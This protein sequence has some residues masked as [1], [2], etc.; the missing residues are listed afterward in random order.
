MINH[1]S[2]QNFVHFREFKY[3]R[4][5][6]INVII[7]E[8]D[9]G[10]TSLL[11]M[12]YATA[13]AWEEFTLLQLGNAE[14][15]AFKQV[16]ARKLKDTFQPDSGKLGDL[17]T[18]KQNERLKANFT[19]FDGDKNKQDIDFRISRDEQDGLQDCK[20]NVKPCPDPDFRALFVPAKEVLT[21]LK[22]IRA[23]NERLLMYG[24]DDTYLDL[25]KSLQIESKK[26]NIA[27]NLV[28]INAALEAL[29]GGKIVQTKKGDFLFKKNNKSDFSMALTAEGVKKLGILSTLIRNR[30]LRKGAI[31]FMDEPEAVLHPKAI[32]VLAKTLFLL[33]ESGI[34]IFLSTHSFFVIKELE[35]IARR[36]KKSIPC[37]SLT[38]TPDGVTAVF[39]D[40]KAGMPSNPIVDVAVEMFNE[41]VALAF[42]K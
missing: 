7:G 11:K 4:L 20:E 42:S 32:K 12:L 10:K 5:G 3:E 33:S 29:F 14:K 23:V 41:E 28:E 15:P 34:Q 38:Q 21:A 26:G 36:E 16:F 24:F 1:V 39:S 22:A 35:I 8:N 40:L 6:Q 18:Q 17:V 31:L 13:K 37:C 9:T 27:K 19:F 2:L 30:E 25:I